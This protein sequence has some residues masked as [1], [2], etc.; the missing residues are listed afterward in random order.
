MPLT[1]LPFSYI[2]FELLYPQL[3]QQLLAILPADSFATHADCFINPTNSTAEKYKDDIPFKL[4][5]EESFYER[6]FRKVV[7]GPGS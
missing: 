4:K 7:A 1:S 5:L 6:K 3:G 2:E